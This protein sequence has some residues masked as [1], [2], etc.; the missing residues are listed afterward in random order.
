VKGTE[1]MLTA[2]A[3]VSDLQAGKIAA[4]ASIAARDELKKKGVKLSSDG[5]GI[6]VPNFPVGYG[7][8]RDRMAGLVDGIKGSGMK[9]VA[10]G[11]AA[12]F[13]AQDAF[14][15][16]NQM[17]AANRAKGFD[18]VYAPN[19]DV[20][21]GSIRALEQ[22]GYKPGTNVMVIGGACHGDDSAVKSGKQYNTI[23]QGSGLE[24]QFTADR[25]LTY[26]KN[27]KVQDGEYL[28]PADA[29]AAPKLPDTISKRNL[30]PLPYVLSASYDSQKLWGEPAKTW[31]TY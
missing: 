17:I 24:G 4:D 31:C 15:L 22:A 14:T 11:N 19:D 1:D 7:A 12:G 5:G 9:V 6:L 16:M 3:G 25:I 10:E 27:P 18:V 26:L 30:I 20:A 2:F 23:I 13:S 8:T 21:I 28:A 29:D